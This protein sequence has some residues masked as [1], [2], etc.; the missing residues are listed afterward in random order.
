MDLTVEGTQRSAAVIYPFTF[1]VEVLPQKLIGEK[2]AALKRPF[3]F[4]TDTP[5]CRPPVESVNAAEAPPEGAID[6]AKAAI[7]VI[8]PV[9]ISELR[10]ANMAGELTT[11]LGRL[12]EV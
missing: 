4:V 6:P 1:S 10:Q 9:K 5:A 7:P 11:Y 3:I 8:A 12:F 2:P